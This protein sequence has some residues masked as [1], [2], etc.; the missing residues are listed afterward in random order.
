MAGQSPPCPADRPVDEIIAELN[1]QKSKKS[2]RNKN[3]L[4]Q[5][6]CI[7][8]WCREAARTPPTVPQPA[9]RAETPGAGKVT[10]SKPPVDKCD[11]AME[12]ALDA[13]HNVEVGDFSFEEK[14][15]RG[16]LLRYEDAVE[17]KP[18]D[19]AIHVRL[20]RVFE[21]LNKLAQAMEHYKAAEKLAGPERWAEEAR[22]AVARLGPQLPASQ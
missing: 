14:N 9:P 17:Q 15:Y 21:K 3:P 18:G 4:P 11:E 1:K 12:M 20:G 10:S 16:A 22:G 5:T 8:G 19:P 2:S 7:W 13:A 6:I